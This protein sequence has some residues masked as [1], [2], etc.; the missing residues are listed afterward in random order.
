MRFTY[1]FGRSSLLSSVYIS[2]DRIYSSSIL[3]IYLI[4]FQIQH[5]RLTITNPI[6]FR[7]NPI[8]YIYHPCYKSFTMIFEQ[9]K[10]LCKKGGAHSGKEVIMICVNPECDTRRLCCLACIDEFHRKHELI[11]LY[12]FNDMLKVL[13]EQ[14]LPE[15]RSAIIA[16]VSDF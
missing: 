10:T 15:T 13:T 14:S 5:Q 8:H 4:I 2:P 12:K 7:F 9:S 6:P 11:S 16:S 1:Y 3:L